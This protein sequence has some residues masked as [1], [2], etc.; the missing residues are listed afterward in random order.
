MSN[1]QLYIMNQ[2][3]L[4]AT[5]DYFKKNNEVNTFTREIAGFDKYLHQAENIQEKARD[6]EIHGMDL[7]PVV[8]DQGIGLMVGDE[9]FKMTEW[10][11]NQFCSKT[12]VPSAYAVKM[13]EAKKFD[14]FVQNFDSW[15][16]SHAAGK[17]LMIRTHE[18]N[19]RGILSERFNKTDMDTVLPMVQ[20]GLGTTNMNFRMDKGILNP[21]YANLRMISD[22]RVDIGDDPHHVGFSFTTSDVGR[23]SMKMEF[24]VYRSR[25]TNGML[26]GKHGGVLFRKKHTTKDFHDPNVFKEQIIA[27]LSNLDRLTEMVQMSLKDAQAK[28]VK[29]EDI[30]R[31]I[32]QFKALSNISKKE[33]DFIHEELKNRMQGYDKV[34]RTVWSV[35]NAFTELAQNYRMDKAEMMEDFAGHLIL[36]PNTAVA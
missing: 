11:L 18:D 32:Q 8:D 30:A 9:R 33:T 21:E 35:S 1:G 31:V 14:L 10:S 34:D 3:G 26:F 36:N 22:S 20:E 17:K 16:Q 6:I 24:F 25:C 19:V 28:Q 2:N 15:I 12:G 23:A 4:Q 27:S 13:A 5:N 29:D 7:K